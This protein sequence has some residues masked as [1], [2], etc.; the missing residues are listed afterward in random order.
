VIYDF[1]SVPEYSIFSPRGTS[2]TCTLNAQP[3]AG[4][5]LGKF[6]G[7]IGWFPKQYCVEIVADE[8]GDEE[9]IGVPRRLRKSRSLCTMGS[10]VWLDL[11]VKGERERA[12]EREREREQVTSP[13]S[14]EAVLRRNR[15]R[16][17]GRR[18]GN[19]G[20]GLVFKA[21]RL[22]FHS[23]LGLRVIKKK[24]KKITCPKP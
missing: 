1:G 16:R 20:G 10:T 17:R 6:Q 23:T 22:L 3:W 8:E 15:R 5:W 18:G 4:W 12:S 11:W 21:H 7:K 9:V 13:W 24:K 19:I 14:S 2:P